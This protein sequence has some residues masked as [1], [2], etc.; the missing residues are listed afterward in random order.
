M[1]KRVEVQ[2]ASIGLNRHTGAGYRIIIRHTG[3]EIRGASAVAG[4]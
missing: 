2:K 4:D 3:V 1:Q